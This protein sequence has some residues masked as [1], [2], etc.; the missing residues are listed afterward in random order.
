MVNREN[1]ATELYNLKDDLEQAHN[2]IDKTE[3]GELIDQLHQ[4]FLKYNDHNSET[5]E[6]RTTQPFYVTK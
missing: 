2:L 4:K 1:K 3:H 6:P 5:K